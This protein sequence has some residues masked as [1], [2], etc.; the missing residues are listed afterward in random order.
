MD[1]INKS[2]PYLLRSE[3]EKIIKNRG[4]RVKRSQLK[5][6]LSGLVHELEVH[7]IE[8]ELQNEEL[9]LSRNRSENLYRIVSENMEDIIT[10]HDLDLKTIYAS[11][12]LK[13]ITGL[14]LEEFIVKNFLNFFDP[15]LDEMADSNKQLFFIV[16]FKHGITGLEIKLEMFWKTIFN[17]LGKPESFL[18][19][20]RDVTE[21]ELVLEELKGSLERE[22]ELNLF[23]SKFI[24]MT[25]HE[26]R[27]PLATIQSSTD[28]IEIIS[29]G[30][31]E[32]KAH[33]GLLNHVRKIHVQLSRLT[34]IISDVLLFENNK[35]GRLGTKQIEMDLKG[36]L[37]QL[38]FNQF[39][40]KENETKIELELGIKPVIL[41]SDPELLFH[42][43]RNLIENAIKYTPEGSPKPILRIIR[44]E[45]SVDVQIVDF[46]I[47]IPQDEKKF[48]FNNFFRGSNVSNIKG[49]GLGL[50]IVHDLV[51]KLGGTITFSSKE[52]QGST[53]II[54]FPCERTKL[55]D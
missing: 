34:R 12:S 28:L 54:S 47:G 46:G 33:D 2:D 36:L 15:K 43:F 7:Q 30:V 37:I 45:Q 22:V 48:L 38:V 5:L 29:D 10:L 27:T 14:N 23:K 24:S 53:F 6:S 11:P 9:K 39:A 13:K 35:E 40:I 8:L 19:A 49:T 25:S 20:S 16:P 32:E 52:N 18:L 26:L 21:R 55:N 41:K 31:K 3:A 50:S 17:H 44:N 1:F 42:V 51:K 4:P